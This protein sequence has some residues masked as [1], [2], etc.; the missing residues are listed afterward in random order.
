[1]TSHYRLIITK[2]KLAWKIL[3]SNRTGLSKCTFELCAVYLLSSRNIFHSPVCLL[4]PTHPCLTEIPPTFRFNKNIR[5]FIMSH[6]IYHQTI[7]WDVCFNVVHFVLQ[8]CYYRIRRLNEFETGRPVFF[9]DDNEPYLQFL[10]YS[11][12][13]KQLPTSADS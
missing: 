8:D 5:K 4:V 7:V 10:A 2:Y 3:Y 9:I 13:C 12:K 11:N 1:M 6:I